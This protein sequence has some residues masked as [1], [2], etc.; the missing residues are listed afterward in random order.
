MSTTTTRIDAGLAAL[1]VIVGGIFM[2]H[3]AQKVFVYGFAGVTG[4]FE[5][6][7][8]PLASVAGPTV[9]L[10]ELLGGLALVLG[11]FTPL[12]AG[13]LAAVMLGALVMVHLPAGFFAPD[14][15]EFVLALFASA[16]ALAL[17]GPGS[18]SLDGLRERRRSAA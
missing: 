13:G 15:I 4:A 1:R 16:V 10:V 12:V 5:G 7:G 2:A 3:G 8:I 18:W 6:M 17:T 11:L 14:G 9:A